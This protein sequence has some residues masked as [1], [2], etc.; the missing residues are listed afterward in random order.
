MRDALIHGHARFYGVGITSRRA[1]YYLSYALP[2]GGPPRGVATVK[3]NLEA[4]ER[5][6]RDL[7]GDVLV[8][9]ERQV[10]ILAS[11][12]EWKCTPISPPSGTSTTIVGG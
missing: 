4:A 3:V 6:W 8:V 11:R 9:D 1:G 2:K 5:E 10:V 7:P 12:A